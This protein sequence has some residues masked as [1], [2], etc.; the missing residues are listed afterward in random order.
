[1]KR[2]FRHSLV[3]AAISCGGTFAMAQSQL[4]CLQDGL[5]Y[6]VAEM[7]SGAP[8]YDAGD[9]LIRGS[10]KSLTMLPSSE[11]GYGFIRVEI[12]ENVRSGKPSTK[13]SLKFGPE[14]AW[15]L[16]KARVV[17]DIDLEDCY[18]VLRFESYGE[19]TFRLKSLGNLK[20]GQ[21]RTFEIFTS[22]GYETPQQ[23]HIYSGKEEIRSSLV[24][25]D[26]R[27]DFGQL[28]MASN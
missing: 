17:A 8:Y 5:L 27:Y 19:V 18:C 6:P 21:A 20:A 7:R 13:S 12:L 23:L 14:R 26:Y 9:R 3:L 15:Y 10:R 16:L 4:H 25:G 28:V 22:V 24:P 2:L 11:F 1:M